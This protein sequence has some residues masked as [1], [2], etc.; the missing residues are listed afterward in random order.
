[1]G[2]TQ[3]YYEIYVLN[4]YGTDIVLQSLK[5]GSGGKQVASFDAAALGG[6]ARP[7]GMPG[8]KPSATIP[9][10]TTSVIYVAFDFPDP[11]RAS[12][13]LDDALTFQI[14]KAN[15]HS[16]TVTQASLHV[17]RR[18]PLVI[19]PP[20]RGDGWYAGSGPSNS[21]IHRRTIFY[22]N[23]R[24]VIGQRFAID[25]LQGKREGNHWS[26]FHGDSSRNENWYCY[27]APLHAV[28]DG[29]VVGL[30]T[31]I[32]ENV[33]DQ[34]P[35]VKIT[36]ETLGGNYVVIDIGYGRYAFYAHLIPHSATVKIGDRVKAGEVIG[37]LGNSGNSTA[38]RAVQGVNPDEFETE[39]G[40]NTVGDFAAYRNTMPGDGAVVD[41]GSSS[42]Q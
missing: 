31:D 34:K 40:V 23:G 7:L 21:S 32:P 24:P 9:A 30:K 3:V 22:Q 18:P 6:M 39:T 2:K 36:Q 27:N 12:T 26:F 35:V 11:Q 19:E 25:W 28:A 42:P 15:N 16:F 13:E 10:A 38:F 41:F 14:P 20:L 8:A 29:L 37:R 4:T 17:V 33:P 1:M 5:V